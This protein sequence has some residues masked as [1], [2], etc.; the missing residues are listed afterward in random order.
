MFVVYRT[1]VAM[2]CPESVFVE[3]R[4]NFLIYLGI[5]V[6]TFFWGTNFN[7]G[8]YV[9][10]LHQMPPVTAALERFSIASIG[11]LGVTAAMGKLRLH[12]LLKNLPAFIGLGILGI[13]WF[14]LAMFYG[15]RATTPVNAALIMATTPLTTLLLAYFFEKEKI[16]TNRAIGIALGMTGVLLVVSKGSLSALLSLHVAQGDIIIFGGSIGWA[17]YTVLSRKF[18]KGAN[19]FEMTAYSMLFGTLAMIPIA[20]WL[21]EPF[22]AMKAATGTMHLAIIYMGL[23]GSMLAYL[24]WF[25]GIEHVGPARTAIFFNLVP[26]STMAVSVMMGQHPNIWQLTGAVIVVMGVLFTTGTHKN[27]YAR[28]MLPIRNGRQ[29][30]QS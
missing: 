20:F 25:R 10:H 1:I 23:C 6:C 8:A 29:K 19:L 13:T 22:V 12:I 26:V 7:A 21:E 18:I 11:L 15:V 14:S 17:L 2:C 30:V 3:N 5:V 9:V 4:P 16:D 28:L 24:F 27:I